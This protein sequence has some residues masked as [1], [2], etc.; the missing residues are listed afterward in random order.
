MDYLQRIL[1][2]QQEAARRAHASIS[3]HYEVP[4]TSYGAV[5]IGTQAWRDALPRPH[6]ADPKKKHYSCACPSSYRLPAPHPPGPAHLDRQPAPRPFIVLDA[7][8]LMS[9]IVRRLVL[10]L[11]EAGVYQPVWTERIGEE[12]RRNA[13]RIW[14]S[15]RKSWRSNG[16]T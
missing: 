9:G 8:V 3:L 15:R 12:W 11:A 7:C 6:R 14:E 5:R 16:R 13:S 10:R 1:A 4:R 2:G